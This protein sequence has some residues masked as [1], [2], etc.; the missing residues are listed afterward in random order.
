MSGEQVLDI[1]SLEFSNHLRPDWEPTEEGCA[2]DD[3]LGKYLLA[4]PIEREG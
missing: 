4:W 3:A 1:L 2:I